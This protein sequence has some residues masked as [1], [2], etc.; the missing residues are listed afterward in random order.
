[1]RN[2]IHSRRISSLLRMKSIISSLVCPAVFGI[3]LSACSVAPSSWISLYNGHDLNGWEVTSFGGE[4]EVEVQEGRIILPM[5]SPL[6]GVRASEPLPASNQYELEI[7]ASRE[8][9][10]DFFCGL[11]FPVGESFAT[12]ILGGWGG[13]LCG[14]S[15]VDFEDAS[16][17][18]TTSYYSFEYHKKYRLRVRVTDQ[19]IGTW[20]DDEE[21]FSVSTT[22]K[23][24]SL[25]TEMLPTIPL[26]I[27]S[28]IT[29]AAVH[30][31]RWRALPAND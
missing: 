4:G 18:S 9:G 22:G 1:M 16:T 5:G 2:R 11:T 6:T 3:V 27:S 10:S 26:G 13:G 15:C 29:T 12:I 28:F 24:I 25:R 23:H 20:I 7:V 8:M 19:E 17:N 21:L 30:S 31:I 14:L